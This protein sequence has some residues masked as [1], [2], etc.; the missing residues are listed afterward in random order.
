MTDLTDAVIRAIRDYPPFRGTWDRL[1]DSE[2][3]EFRTVLDRILLDL[4]AEE[5]P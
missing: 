2:R 1:T 4:D 3:R 5:R